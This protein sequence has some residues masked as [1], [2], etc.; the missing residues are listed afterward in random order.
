MDLRSENLEDEFNRPKH[1]C[2]QLYTETAGLELK[3]SCIRCS[4]QVVVGTLES[5]PAATFASFLW[6]CTPSKASWITR[7]HLEI[8][9]NAAT[10]GVL[11]IEQSSHF[12]DIAN[13]CR[14]YPR[15]HVSYLIKEPA[16]LR[17]HYE[18]HHYFYMGIFL[19][20][21]LR[22]QDMRHILM[23]PNAFSR[24]MAIAEN[25]ASAEQV[26]RLDVPNLRIAVKDFA[27][28][29]VSAEAMW[30]AAWSSGWGLAGFN[31]WLQHAR[32]W[33]SNGF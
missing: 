25:W 22:H 24:S 30:K 16:Q 5:G 7:V 2:R 8:G 21:A 26:K 6:N 3:F 15:A 31:R 27:I 32:S 4:G 12:I 13:F 33:V 17:S 20:I 1:V 14:S 23:N 19:K 9:G 28:T 18:A 10:I 29:D 11:L